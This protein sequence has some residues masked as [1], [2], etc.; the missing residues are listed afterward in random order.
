V[1][2]ALDVARHPGRMVVLGIPPTRPETG[3]GYIE[4]MSES[5]G[6]KGFPVF[7][8]LRFTEKPE[9]KLAQEYVA[10]GNY[11]WNAGMF[12]GAFPRFL[13]SRQFCR[14]HMRRS[15][16]SPH[17]SEPAATKRKL[18]AIYPKLENISV[19]Y[20]VLRTGH[21]GRRR[22]ACLV[23]PRSNRLERHRLLG[24]RAWAAAGQKL[25][26]PKRVRHAGL[27]PGRERN[28]ISCLEKSPR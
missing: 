10:T 13:K 24:R 3:F 9:V 19:D 28:L 27:R 25:H 26:G 12:S 7:P 11:H 20:A 18:R 6:L 2:A 14:K 22:A 15:K 21:A 16:S 8:V 5:I 23:I 17:S 4:G 1:S